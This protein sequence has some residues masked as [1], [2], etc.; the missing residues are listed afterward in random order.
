MSPMLSEKVK[1]K[2]LSR[3]LSAT[4]KM[5]VRMMEDLLCGFAISNAI[6]KK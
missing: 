4:L 1:K 3:L 6:K 2:M 5:Y